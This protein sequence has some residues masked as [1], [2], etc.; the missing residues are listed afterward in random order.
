MKAVRLHA[1]NGPEE[2]FYEDTPQPL[3]GKGEVLVHVA[4]TGVTPTELTWSTTWQTPTGTP[5]LYPIPGHDLS[6]VVVYIGSDVT[7]IAVGQAV[8]GLT[9]FRR[10]GAEAEYT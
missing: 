8:Y 6:G 4:A 5:R 2:L 10:D 9:D 3:P 7:G 1:R